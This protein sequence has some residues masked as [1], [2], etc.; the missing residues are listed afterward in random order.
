MNDSNEQ[1]DKFETESNDKVVGDEKSQEEINE[2]DDAASSVKDESDSGFRGEIDEDLVYKRQKRKKDTNFY[3]INLTIFII[4]ALLLFTNLFG[5]LFRD[6]AQAFYFDERAFLQISIAIKVFSL[7]ALLFSGYYVFRQY[8]LGENDLFDIF[9]SS[10]F[11]RLRP[12]SSSKDYPDRNIPRSRLLEVEDRLEIIEAGF[13]KEIDD[14]RVEIHN[15]LSEEL[16]KI[17]TEKLYARLKTELEKRNEYKELVRSLDYM[18]DNLKSYE[19]S[20]RR[21]LTQN[22]AIGAIGAVG[23]LGVASKLVFDSESQLDTTIDLLKHYLPWL[24]LIIVIQI[25]SFFFLRLYRDS[26][27]TERY[28][29]NEI[30][31]I[32]SKRAAIFLAH[33]TGNAALIKSVTSDL[34][35]VERNRFLE[36][37]QT[38][39]E[40]ES[41]KIEVAGFKEGAEAMAGIMPWAKKQPRRATRK[42]PVARKKK[43]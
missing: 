4:S 23:A 16:S 8:L 26:I 27:K 33:S 17:E 21:Q 36:K 42:T 6:F 35:N 14:H 19:E 7:F 34:S 13:K 3:A 22:L 31:N 38:T 18:T 12:L 39:V 29:R 43:P 10:I 30:T 9:G 32:A 25:M 37:G 41:S 28:L 15:V 40:L 1:K 2:A 20:N 24:S 11:R 5:G